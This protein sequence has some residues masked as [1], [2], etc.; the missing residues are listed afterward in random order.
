MLFP[1][2]MGDKKTNFSKHFSVCF[3]SVQQKIAGLPST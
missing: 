2:G 3:F 1:V